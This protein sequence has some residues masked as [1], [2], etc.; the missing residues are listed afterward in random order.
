M[1]VIA[2]GGNTD[3]APGRPDPLLVKLALE[4]N[5]VA[6]GLQMVPNQPLQFADWPHALWE[7]DIIAYSWSKFLRTGDETWP[8]RLP[9]TKAAVR[10][11][12]TVSEF[13]ARRGTPVTRFIVGGASKRGW[14]TCATRAPIRS[15]RASRR[16]STAGTRFSWR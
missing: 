6:S 12:D 10:A 5:A 1:L 16:R 14:T 2:G 15:W 13:C 8:L 3:P 4:T 7:D 9:M 11:M